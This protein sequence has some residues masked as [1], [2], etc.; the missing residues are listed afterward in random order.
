MTPAPG[1]ALIVLGVLSL[2]GFA[3]QGFVVAALL[4]TGRVTSIRWSWRWLNIGVVLIVA[5]CTWLA[6]IS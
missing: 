3:F 4:S 2:C 6:V 1:Y 5:G